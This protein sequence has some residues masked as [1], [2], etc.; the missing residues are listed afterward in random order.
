MHS[1]SLMR[2]S[3][4]MERFEQVIVLSVLLNKRKGS[5]DINLVDE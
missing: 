3:S 2:T 5:L 1:F 4:Y